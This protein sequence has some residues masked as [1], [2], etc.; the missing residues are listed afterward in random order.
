MVGKRSRAVGKAPERD[1]IAPER[2]DA[3]SALDA[4][5]HTHMVT[6]TQAHTPT[7]TPQFLSTNPH[8]TPTPTV[9]MTIQGGRH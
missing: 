2:E 6:Q 4:L 5:T 7:H 1:C 3:R 8:S 9:F